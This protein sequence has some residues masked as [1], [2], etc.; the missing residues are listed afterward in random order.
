MNRTLISLAPK[1]FL[2][3]FKGIFKIGLVCLYEYGIYSSKITK[4]NLKGWPNTQ[5]IAKTNKKCIFHNI[6]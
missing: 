6:C 2:E 4:I 3:V 1:T 5:N